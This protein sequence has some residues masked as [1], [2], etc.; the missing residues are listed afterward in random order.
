MDPQP[1]NPPQPDEPP[2]IS[3]C[4]ELGR[5]FQSL[6][7]PAHRFE[8]ALSRISTRLGLDGQFF[9]LPTAF[10]ASLGKDGRHWT[11]IQRSPSGDVDLGKLSDLQATTDDLLSGSL[12]V[13]DARLRIRAIL[14]APDRWGTPLTV[15]CFG[16][17]SA[18]AALFFGGGWREM[19]ITAVLGSLIGTTA[20]LLG[21]SVRLSRLVYPVA[22]ALVGFLAVAA[23]ARFD[24]VSPQVLTLA[25]LI[26]LVPGLRLVLAM[27]E[28]ATGNLVA[29]TA[30][31]M[32]AGLTFL[33]LGFGVALGQRF[34][35]ALMPHALLGVPVPLPAWTLLPTL[36]LAAGAFMVIFKARTSDLLWI[37][38]ACTLAFYGTR[39]GA[40]LLG[41]QLGVAL[42]ALA[43]GV[44]SNLFTRLR[45]RPSVV[46]MLP[47]LMVLVPG[48]L[49][50]RGLGLILQNQLVLGLDTAFQAL[51]V[52]IALL[53]GLLLA[54]AAVQPRTA[55]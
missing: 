29:G 20:L 27:N 7:I 9:A 51:F 30:R 13:A 35:A 2:E 3:L 14:A 53:M 12:S 42:G 50:F 11:F 49:G 34:A 1:T 6:G 47:G 24:H 36:L 54:Q 28:L 37:F 8:D 40:A 38:A 32:D 31:L 5:A 33:S 10:F 39:Q 19:L 52:T 48:G 25:G 17:G 41:P 15:L 45:R 22:G 55:L 44:A 46:T 23:A 16:L 21:R 26:V 43:L 18:P 4:L